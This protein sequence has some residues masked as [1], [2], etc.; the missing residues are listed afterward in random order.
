[1][2]G[3][4]WQ[5][6]CYYVLSKHLM[7]TNFHFVFCSILT[8]YLDEEVLFS[9]NSLEKPNEDGVSI[10]FY[11]QKIFP[12]FIY[13]VFDFWYCYCYGYMLDLE[14]RTLIWTTI[15]MT[16]EWD[17]FLERIGCNNEEDIKLDPNLE[18]D[19]R[20]WASYRGQTLTKTGILFLI[21]SSELIG[22]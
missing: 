6:W 18:E 10:L 8:P 19:L 13:S 20:L 11:L 14:W 3:P 4:F 15:L 5:L 2:A 1:M 21:L 17:N 9:I 12:G 22:C 7:F 16:D